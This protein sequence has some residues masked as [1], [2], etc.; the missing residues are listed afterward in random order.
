MVD[1]VGKLCCTLFVRS[2]ISAWSELSSLI[3]Y[4]LKKLE[5]VALTID[6]AITASLIQVMMFASL[7]VGS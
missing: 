5:L 7:D 6:I 4:S 3:K 2:S 1:P